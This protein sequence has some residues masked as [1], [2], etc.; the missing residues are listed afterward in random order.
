MG[1][2]MVGDRVKLRADV[3]G[4]YA[5]GRRPVWGSVVHV[6]PDALE[7]EAICVA[8]D[9]W[10]WGHDGDQANGAT[11]CWWVDE[12]WLELESTQLAFQ[13]VA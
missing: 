5:V 6:R 2:P 7:D 9:R 13:F 10:R 1:K 3:S 4:W 11:N 8:W 12:R